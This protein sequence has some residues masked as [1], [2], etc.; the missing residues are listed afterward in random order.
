[1]MSMVCPAPPYYIIKRPV[2]F[3]L[4]EDR[5]HNNTHTPNADKDIDLEYWCKE[6]HIRSQ[7]VPDGNGVPRVDWNAGLGADASA[8][9]NNCQKSHFST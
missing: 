9:E 4:F 6:G 1:M 2:N 7:S 5:I 3:L 8:G